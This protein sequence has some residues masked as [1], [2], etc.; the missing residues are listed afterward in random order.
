M[1]TRSLLFALAVLS[2]CATAPAEEASIP[3]KKRTKAGLYLTAVDA[4]SLW[5]ATPEDVRILDVR[6]PEEYLHVGHAPMAWNV[7]Y[8]LQTY[9]WDANKKAFRMRPDPAFVQHV[10]KIAGPDEVLLVMCRS[11]GRSAKAVNAVTNAGFI[12]VWTIVDGMEGDKVKD[13]KSPHFGQRRKNG[14]K[15]AGLPWTYDV[16]PSK[17]TLP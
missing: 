6:T 10:R 12:N 9:E 7:P 14:W 3:A 11:G 13:P 5:Q 1:A 16:D 2:S 15:N 8:A 4:Y 17:M